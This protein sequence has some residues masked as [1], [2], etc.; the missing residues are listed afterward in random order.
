MKIEVEVNSDEADELVRLALISAYENSLEYDGEE[1]H[2]AYKI[3]IKQFSEPTQWYKWDGS[4]PVCG[5]TEVH[6][7]DC[8][9]KKEY[10]LKKSKDLT[11]EDIASVK[12]ILSDEEAEEFYHR[13]IA[14]E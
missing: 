5:G 9:Y 1:V 14:G 8:G 2:N 11:P 7:M 12:G 3:V 10:P 13:K 4:C 6:K